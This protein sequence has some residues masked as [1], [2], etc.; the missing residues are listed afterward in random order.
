MSKFQIIVLAIF[1]V[2]I[3]IGIAVFATYR[4]NKNAN[5]ELAQIT[6]WGTFPAETFNKYIAEINQTLAS[7]MKVSYVQKTP[8]TF[9]GDFIAAL[10][11]GAGPDG[12]L[13][14]ADMLM[15]HFDKLTLIPY[16]ALPQR[17][18][19]DSYIGEGQI[20]LTSDGIRA[21]PFIVDPLVMYWNKD[22]YGTAGIATY[23]KSWDEFKGLNKKLTVKDENGNIRKSAIA[24]GDF[25]NVVNS[26]EIL[27]TLLLQL[28]SQV[29]SFDQNG[30]FESALIASDKSNP[31]GAVNFFTQF[32]NPNNENYSWN[33]GMNDSRTAFLSGTLATYFG[34][35]SELQSLRAK[36]ANLNF[37]VAQIPQSKTNGVKT[38]YGKIYGLSIVRTSAKQNDVYQSYAIITN[39]TNLKKLSEMTYLPSVNTSVI[40]G[41]SQDPYIT[42]FNQAALIARSWFDANASESNKIFG[43]MINAVTSGAKNTA[44]ALND[45]NDAYNVVLRQAQQ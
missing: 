24:M 8:S 5:T 22:M 37:D 10:A 9:S 44:E 32:V 40:A 41:G 6:V 3:G 16:T 1:I 12:I 35:A 33:R 30:R 7:P 26:R 23:P 2:C 28:G 13:I 31:T 36:N 18:F 39:P 21:I 15:P 19:M 34:F 38:T 20:Y 14:P 27:G 17:T 45:A 42:I 25:T 4:G 29:T 11:R 43:N